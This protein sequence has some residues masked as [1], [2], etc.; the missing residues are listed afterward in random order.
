MIV[1]EER[2]EVLRNR[3]QGEQWGWR[4]GRRGGVGRGSGEEVLEDDG[5]GVEVVW[6]EVVV[7]GGKGDIFPNFFHGLWK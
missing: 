3:V 5:G 7:G 4:R 2:A 6:G 1:Q